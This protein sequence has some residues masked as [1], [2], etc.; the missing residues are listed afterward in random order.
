MSTIKKKRVT[1]S[2]NV[3]K[4]GRYLKILEQ[5]HDDVLE[6]INRMV[7]VSGKVQL[8][9]QILM[10]IQLEVTINDRI[11]VLKS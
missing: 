1:K 11:K 5:S 2:K 4:M 10:L 6:L 8:N 7:P 3:G 9:N